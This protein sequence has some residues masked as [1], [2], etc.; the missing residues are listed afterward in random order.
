M[1]LG[2]LSTLNGA[3][4]DS[5]IAEAVKAQDSRSNL[6]RSKFVSGST[7][8]KPFKVEPDTKWVLFF[9][10]EVAVPFNPADVEDES[11]NS[12]NPFVMPGTVSAAVTVLKKLASSNDKIKEL[13]CNAMGA[14][15][16]DINWDIEGIKDTAERM[17]WHKISRMSYLTKYTQK[18]WRD[19][20]KKFPAKVGFEPVLDEEGEIIG[21]VGLGWNLHKLESDL[22]NIKI[23][24]LEEQFKPGGSR[25]NEPKANLEAEIKSLWENKLIRNP[26]LESYTRVFAFKLVNSGEGTI[27]DKVAKEFNNSKKL[28]PY[29]F[30]MKVTTKDIAAYENA[31]ASTKTDNHDNF[32]EAQ[33]TIP[34]EDPKDNMA[35]YKD[36]NRSNPNYA[37]TSIST[38]PAHLNPDAFYEAFEN[39]MLDEDLSSKALLE[40]SIY[41]YK[42]PSDTVLSDILKNNIVRYDAAMKSQSILDKYS[43]TIA[44]IDVDLTNKIAESIMDGEDTGLDT[45]P[46]IVNSS[47]D[48]EETDF[49]TGDVGDQLKSILEGDDNLGTDEFGSFGE[50]K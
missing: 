34:A 42:R 50:L 48:T 45:V 38:D 26:Y 17:L 35:I 41:A 49:Q 13:L 24:M 4:L 39:F 14:D 32:I 16:K 44:L 15:E 2:E 30:T 29:Q 11:F 10:L 7:T 43:E 9:P 22:I 5:F 46:E 47:I 21:S 12:S 31:F 8:I 27:D 20:T 36:Q 28:A 3:S 40:K 1:K 6:L 25:A 33:L 37:N 18:V 19:L 23:Q